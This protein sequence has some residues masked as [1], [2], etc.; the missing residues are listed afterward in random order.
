MTNNNQSS[1]TI[2][3]DPYEI[4]SQKPIFQTINTLSLPADTIHVEEVNNDETK[5]FESYRIRPEGANNTDEQ[6][7][8]HL[9]HLSLLQQETQQYQQIEQEGPGDYSV[10][11]TQTQAP[12]TR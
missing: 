4:N 5:A 1:K 8:T 7:F 6:L 3:N 10:E 12:V 2:A 9:T 11:Y